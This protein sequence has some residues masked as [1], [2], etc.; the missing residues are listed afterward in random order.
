MKK[1]FI[2]LKAFYKKIMVPAVFL[3]IVIF[4][5]ELLFAYLIGT[6][7]YYTLTDKLFSDV[8]QD[9]SSLY[10]MKFT[11]EGSFEELIP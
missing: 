7:R 4:I 8:M 10:V 5:A 1:N 6:Y 2:L 9:E 3:L 11:L